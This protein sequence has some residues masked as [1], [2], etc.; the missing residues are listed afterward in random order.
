MA[1]DVSIR[2]AEELHAQFE[3]LVNNADVDGTLSLY[4]PEAVLMERNGKTIHGHAAIRAHLTAL[5]SLKPT[6]RIQHLKTLNAGTIAILVPDWTLSGKDPNGAPVTDN[7][8][9]YDV[10]RQQADGSWCLVVDNP[11]G[12]SP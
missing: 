9:T 8:R 11:W 5:F 2:P 10:V 3:R 7:G 12:V 4:E 1:S 6:I